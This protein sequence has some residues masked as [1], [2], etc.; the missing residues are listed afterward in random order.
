MAEQPIAVLWCDFGGV[1]TPPV[2][3]AAARIARAAGIPWP[4]LWR[5][6]D[7]VASDLGLRG[8]APL[9][10]GLLSQAEW[11]SR[12]EAALPIRP[13]IE[14]GDWGEHW[15]R[16]RPVNTPLLAALARLRDSGVR[17]GMLTNSV[18]E[19]EPYRE[20]MLRDHVRVFDAV[21]RSHE[22]AIAKPDP[23]IFAVA[24]E[25]LPSG[26]AALLLDD[27]AVNCRAARDFGWQ[28]HLHRDSNDSVRLLARLARRDVLPS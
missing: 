13:A 17:I 22:R 3:E 23:R 21:V 28:A 25:H 4:V 10:R 24:E 9:E 14:L 18:R 8:M 19:W 26:G 27:G 1:L 5:A 11:G 6:I 7:A 15:Y 2:T 20:R 16:D 12:V